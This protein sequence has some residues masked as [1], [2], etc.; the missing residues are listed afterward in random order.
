[1]PDE[2]LLKLFTVEVRPSYLDRPLEVCGDP[3]GLACPVN[4]SRTV[5]LSVNMTYACRWRALVMS[6]GHAAHSVMLLCSQVRA[7]CVAGIAPT[8]SSAQLIADQALD[9]A[10]RVTLSTR[11]VSKHVAL[12]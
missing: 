6:R 10:I 4:T 3:D 2:N 5:K 7:N 1:V 9:L 11:S 12:S 8:A